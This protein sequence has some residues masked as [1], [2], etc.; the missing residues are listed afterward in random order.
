MKSLWNN[1]KAEG[2]SKDPLELRVYTSRLLGANPDLVLHGGGNTSVKLSEENFFGETEE[3]LLVKGSGWDLAT[4]ETPGFAPVRLET[5]KRLA[6]LETLSDSE[7]VR[8][9]RAAMTDPSAPNPS[10]EAILH[11][12]IPFRDVDH[13]HADAVLAVTNHPAGEQS[14]QEIYGNRVI[15]I[16][17][18]MPGFVLAKKVRELTQDKNWSDYEG[19]IL[20]NHGI[21]TFDDEARESYEKMIR[22]VSE[23]EEYVCAKGIKEA[24]KA[25]VQEDLVTLGGI[26]K[27]VSEVAGKPMLAVIDQSDQAGGFSRRQDVSEIVTRGPITPD[28]VLRTKNIPV[29][30]DENPKDE[31]DTFKTKYLE[32]FQRHTDGQLTCLDPAPRWAVWKNFGTLVFGRSV[33]ETGII[34]DIIDHTRKT[35]QQV[36]DWSVWKALP[37]KDLFEVEYWELEQAKLGKSGKAPDFQG[38]I[39]LVSGAASGIGRSC[40][41]TLHQHGAAVLA[42]DLNPEIETIFSKPGIRGLCCDVT[43]DEAIQ[44]AVDQ[45]VRSF[46]GLD[47]LVSNA[48]NFPAGLPLDKMDPETWD[49][50]M[51]LNLSSHQR[52]LTA[53]TPFLQ[54]SLDG[55]VV[56][57]ASRNVPAP[58]PGASAYSVAKAGLTQLARVAALELGSYGVRVN[59]LHPD[60][61]YDT[62]LWSE[63]VLQG[64]ADKYGM[65]VEEYKSRN[66]LKKEVTSREVSEMVAVV[67]GPI[68]SK[69]TGAQIPIDGGNDRVI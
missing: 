55:A 14:V 54:Q 1:E 3:L 5:L 46:G 68:F 15:V 44:K 61:V 53:A 8:Q 57:I 47:I 37:E 26:R 67:A 42:L 51:K 49:S 52:L 66:I 63:G 25:K 22:L 2:F 50:S 41:E 48:G 69:T 4:I 30:L 64:R 38:K 11:A 58:G 23:A 27:K 62:G 59:V 31:V 35:I 18:V 28:H 65:S 12:L 45:T 33:K 60:C 16:P 34:A 43:D 32:Y 6:E 17:Y 10:V 39:A 20:M 40:A 29:I 7:M 19:M 56:F 13:T 21:F 9:Q 24:P 36:E